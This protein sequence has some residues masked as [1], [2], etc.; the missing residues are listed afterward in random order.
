MNVA[1]KQRQDIILNTSLKNF[2]S[3]PILDGFNIPIKQKQLILSSIFLM[4]TPLGFYKS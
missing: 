4:K 1:S 3:I 2:Q